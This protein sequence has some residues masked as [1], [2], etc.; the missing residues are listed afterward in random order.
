MPGEAVGDQ[1]VHA[2]EMMT[3]VK[4]TYGGGGERAVPFEAALLRFVL[5]TSLSFF[6]LSLPALMAIRES[7]HMTAEAVTAT[8]VASSTSGVHS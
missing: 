8:V 6:P 4:E 5:D 3:L 2:S 7:W 1:S